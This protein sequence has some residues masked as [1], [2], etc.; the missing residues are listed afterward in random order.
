MSHTPSCCYCHSFGRRKSQCTIIDLQGIFSTFK[1]YF[2]VHL[3]YL[4][5][6]L[7]QMSQLFTYFLYSFKNVF[8]NRISIYS[9][10][11][12]KRQNFCR[13]M[14]AKANF[15]QYGCVIYFFFYSRENYCGY[16]VIHPI[17]KV[18]QDGYFLDW[19]WNKWCTIPQML[20][21]PGEPNEQIIRKGHYCQCIVKIHLCICLC[22]YLFITCPWK[23]RF[24]AAGSSCMYF[25]GGRSTFSQM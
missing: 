7:L 25:R 23:Q 14:W 4:T 11:N 15:R 8:I 12:L 1:H 21:I 24:K 13:E 19:L 20:Q 17:F 6:T 2:R 18:P 22:V 5:L 3:F 9:F 10:L 16:P